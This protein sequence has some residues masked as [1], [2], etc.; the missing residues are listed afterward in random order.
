[1]PTAVEAGMARKKPSLLEGIASA[2]MTGASV[3]NAANSVDKIIT[4]VSG[5]GDAAK[6]AKEAESVAPV[7]VA[8]VQDTGGALAAMQRRYR[9]LAG[10][11]V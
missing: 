7:P 3:L 8:P 5:A 6:F 11:T 2:I 4:D 9:A 1:M 10:R